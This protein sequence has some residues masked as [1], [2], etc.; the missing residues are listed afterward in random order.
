MVI[1]VVL[2]PSTTHYKRGILFLLEREL[3]AKVSLYQR[4]TLWNRVL[5]RRT[6]TWTFTDAVKLSPSDT[7]IRNRNTQMVTWG[8]TTRLY[9]S[10]IPTC[11]RDR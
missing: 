6:Y 2:F 11:R 8:D 9:I 1:L 3:R 4:L 7:R 5:T 10:P